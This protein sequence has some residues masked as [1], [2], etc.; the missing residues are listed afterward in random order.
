ML[1][2]E[3]LRPV[4]HVVRQSLGPDDLSQRPSSKYSTK[5]IQSI[6]GLSVFLLSYIAMIW[7]G[8]LIKVG[9]LVKSSRLS[10]DRPPCVD[11]KVF[12]SGE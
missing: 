2:L 8:F 3:Y 1:N 9:F 5:V 7:L 12:I 11:Y 6:D 4:G 10:I